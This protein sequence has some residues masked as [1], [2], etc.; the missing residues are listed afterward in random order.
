[1]KKF[2]KRSLAVLLAV[3]MVVGVVPLAGFVGVELPKFSEF[4]KLADSVSEFFYNFGTRAEASEMSAEEFFYYYIDEYYIDEYGNITIIDVDES[5]SGG[6]TIPSSFSGCSVTYIGDRAFYECEGLTSVVIPNSVKSIG[7]AAFYECY[8]LS[9]VIIGNGVR[10][11]GAAAFSC[12]PISN[13]TIPNGVVNIGEFAFEGIN[14]E[15]YIPK[16]VKNIGLC[17]FATASFIEVDIN[18]TV[19]SSDEFGVLFN[20]DKTKLIQYPANNERKSYR[21]FDGVI[22]IAPEAFG[23]C[24]NLNDVIIC[25]SVINIDDEAFGGFEGYLT[26]GAGVSYIGYNTDAS[27]IEVDINNSVYSSDKFGVLFN[28]DK[29]K[30]IR[31]PNKN[32]RTSYQIPEGII[33][34]EPCAF[35][36]SANLNNINISN[37]VTSIGEAAFSEC[38]NL[39]T[40]TIPDSVTSIGAYAFNECEIYEI[41]IGSGIRYIGEHAFYKNGNQSIPGVIYTGTF[42]DWCTIEFEDVYSIPMWCFNGSFVEIDGIP[43]EYDLVIPYGVTKIGDRVF[44]SCENL[45]SVKIPNSVTEIGEFA[46]GSSR[47]LE[48]VVIPNSV[49]DIG[50]GAFFGTSLKKVIIGKGVKNIGESAFVDPNWGSMDITDVYYSGSKEE[51]NSITIGN[52]NEGLINASIHYNYVFEGDDIILPDD[53]DDYSTQNIKVMSYNVYVK[54]DDVTGITNGNTYD[55]SYET[56]VRYIVQNINN[57]MPDSIGLQELTSDMRFMLE[58]YEDLNGGILTANYAGVG[59]Y[60]SKSGKNNEAS[61]IYY[62]K[63]KFS[64]KYSGTF[65]LSESGDEYSTHS[66]SDYP[67]ICTYVLLENKETGLQYLHVNTHLEHEVNSKGNSNQAAISSSEKIIDFVDKKFPNVPVV[68]TGDFNQKKGSAPYNNFIDAGYSDARDIYQGITNTYSNCYNEGKDGNAYEPKVIDH[69]LVNDYF[70]DG[71]KSY[72][73]YDEDYSNSSKYDKFV[74]D[75]PYPSDHHPVV[76]ELEATYFGDTILSK[77]IEFGEN[78]MVE[79]VFKDEWF[80]KSN[81]EYN[82]SLA[83]FCA[84]YVMMGYCYNEDKIK[85]YLSQMG[86]EKVDTEMNTGRDEVNYFIASK[87][88]TVNGKKETLVFSAFIGSFEKQWYSNFDPNG[89]QREKNYAGDKEIGSVHLGFADARDFV[90]QKLINYIA[91]YGIEKDNMKLLVSG[92]S[93]GAA[94]ANLLAAKLIDEDYSNSSASLVSRKD[95]YTYT[96]ATPNTASTEMNV[97]ADKYKCIFNVVNPEDFVT[98]VLPNAWGFY[99]YGTTYVLPSRTNDEN[100][101][102]YLGGMNSLYWLYS[103][104]N[105]YEPYSD[106][107][108]ETAKILKEI[109]SNVKGINEFYSDYF[110]AS[111]VFYYNPFDKNYAKATPFDF[112]KHTLLD[113]LTKEDIAGAI[114]T[115]ATII[116]EPFSMF[117]RNILFYFFEIDWLDTSLNPDI[118]LDFAQAHGMETY[119]AYMNSMTESQIKQTRLYYENI[120]NC[121]VDIEVYDKATNELVGRITNNVIDETVAA[122]KNAIVMDVD[123]D[124]KSFWLPS[125]GDYKVVLI[126]NDEGTMDYTVSNIDSDLGETER[127][128]FFDVEIENSVSME[129]VFVSEET[130][131]DSYT[132]TH[133]KDGTI[134]PTEIIGK[135]Q[136]R[137]FT[138]ITS[139]EGNGIV[140]GKLTATSGDYVTVSAYPGDGGYFTGWYENG[141]LVST[142]INYSFVAKENKK[143]VAK[144]NDFAIRTPSITNISYGDAIILHAD[145]TGILPNGA[146]IK[147]EA[148]NDN[149]SCSASADGTTCKIS[150]NRSGETTFTA[151]VYDKDGNVIGRDTQTMTSKAGF[152]QK[153]IAFFKKLF[154]LTKVIQ[155]SLNTIY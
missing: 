107:E 99:R 120:V 132:L 151:T 109:T 46:F 79:V 59:D 44:S 36:R 97:F 12:C 8:N 131:V 114:S 16:S 149:F 63:N 128:N 47:Y 139:S 145:V 89:T 122:G 91:K 115:I 77:N 118:N 50:S 78:E 55:C 27:F 22:A 40:I 31:Y 72:T 25:D 2:L 19:Y 35:E 83:Q 38:K 24:T 117:Y 62:N 26:I 10:D 33:N 94:T 9:N 80:D 70:A 76:V 155:Q 147:W 43:I 140:V 14:T 23:F 93:R 123:G 111:D 48:S 17:A 21:I 100:W 81:K 66:A 15:I 103:Y 20:K 58:N 42:A 82:H 148:D 68:I 110:N 57:N 126:G 138:I 37:S 60:R 112:F 113:F 124:S 130:K 150:P 4:K 121:P 137:N 74:L 41:T 11:I 87:D 142:D 6:I 3:V 98:K 96:F 65:W 7:D 101:R 13:I 54:N 154:G 116:L 39:G 105:E 84:D 5:I 95:I 51:W 86:F 52:D 28:K 125:N 90:Y 146:S 34:I 133:E 102:A 69:I 1:M 32:E 67:R 56:R 92:H 29:T 106:G 108:K 49:T 119:A 85:N 104:G 141:K 135:E 30:L 127:V 136:L 75:Y 61:L 134:M 71:I 153:I 18:N 143:L 73:V 53:E 144:F 152:F 88:I 129:G 64:L 45:R